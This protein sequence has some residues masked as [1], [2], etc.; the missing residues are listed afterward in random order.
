MLCRMLVI[1]Y[2]FGKNYE[3]MTKVCW[4]KAQY[5]LSSKIDDMLLNYKSCLGNIIKVKTA[6]TQSIMK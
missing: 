4:D 1:C 6:S 2:V 3:N 5:F